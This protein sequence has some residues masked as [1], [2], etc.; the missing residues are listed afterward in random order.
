MSKSTRAADFV[1]VTKGGTFI[2]A[3]SKGITKIDQ[4]ID[5]LTNT[6]KA[7]YSKVKQTGGK[8]SVAAE[9]VFESVKDLERLPREYVING[10]HLMKQIDG[11]NVP[12]TIEVLDEGRRIIQIPI[13][14]RFLS[15]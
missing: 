3:D 9:L 2:V 11:K 13:Q 5:Q 10:S 4:G 6:V 15:K 1:G 7:L 12:A 14:V 8:F